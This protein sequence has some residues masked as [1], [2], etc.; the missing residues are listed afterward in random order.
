MQAS[1]KQDQNSKKKKKKR[2][3]NCKRGFLEKQTHLDY[4]Q[5]N[6]SLAII[7]INHDNQKK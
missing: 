4:S 7:M 5:G 6:H 1:R 2:K 3:K